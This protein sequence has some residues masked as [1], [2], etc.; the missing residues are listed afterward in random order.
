MRSQIIDNCKMIWKISVIY[1]KIY[2]YIEIVSLNSLDLFKVG[3]HLPFTVIKCLF[4][5]ISVASWVCTKAT[6]A[7]ICCEFELLGEEATELVG[8]MVDTV[9]GASSG[10]SA[11]SIGTTSMIETPSDVVPVC[12]IYFFCWQI[13]RKHERKTIRALLLCQLISFVR[14]FL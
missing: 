1:S 11:W 13:W 5:E 7:V 6:W 2:Y 4:S 8:K 9:I 14:L 10:E 3:S 12:K